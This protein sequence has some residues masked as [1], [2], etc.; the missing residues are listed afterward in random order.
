VK[1]SETIG[2]RKYL[3]EEKKSEGKVAPV[4][5]KKVNRGRKY[6]SPLILKLYA[7]WR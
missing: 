1:I 5:A 7:R 4:Q 2:D 6:I 3:Y